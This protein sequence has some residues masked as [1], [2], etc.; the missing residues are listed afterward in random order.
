MKKNKK[1]RG[2]VEIGQMEA[3]KQKKYWYES[4]DNIAET[5]RM[6]KPIEGV[7]GVE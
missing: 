7:E 6:E 2:Y 4:F 1:N 5:D 3:M